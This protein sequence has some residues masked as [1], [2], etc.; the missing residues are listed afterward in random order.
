MSLLLLSAKYS[1][2]SNNQI[3]SFNLVTY[4]FLK[5]KMW[6]Y[7]IE[8]FCLSFTFRTGMVCGSN[9]IAFL[10]LPWME[11]FTW[12]KSVYCP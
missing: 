8:F 12:G 6:S 10:L 5:K 9:V 7:H 2:C 4:S 1:Y 3:F 11:D